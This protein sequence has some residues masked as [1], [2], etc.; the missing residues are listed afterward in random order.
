MPMSIGEVEIRGRISGFDQGGQAASRPRNKQP[1]QREVR[2]LAQDAIAIILA[3]G[4]RPPCSWDKRL[5]Q[6]GGTLFAS[7]LSGLR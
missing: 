4:P 3:G 1:A 6:A 7:T 5:V 2:N